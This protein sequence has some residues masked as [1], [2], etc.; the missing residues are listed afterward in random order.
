MIFLNCTS[1][2]IVVVDLRASQVQ[3]PSHPD[4]LSENQ[5]YHSDD[6]GSTF[7]SACTFWWGRR[8]VSS[9]KRPLQ[10][11]YKLLHYHFING[12]QGQGTESEKDVVGH[13]IK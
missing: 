1:G 6:I 9:A 5:L 11:G 13:S 10:I 2:S 8:S 3:F 7:G 4:I 12:V